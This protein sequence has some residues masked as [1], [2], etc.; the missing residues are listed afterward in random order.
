MPMAARSDTHRLCLACR[1]IFHATNRAYGQPRRLYLTVKPGACR[2]AASL[3][4]AVRQT[5]VLFLLAKS[6]AVF[7]GANAAPGR[8]VVFL[9]FRRRIE[10]RR[11]RRGCNG[12][13]HGIQQTVIFKFAHRALLVG[14]LQ[15]F[16]PFCTHRNSPKLPMPHSGS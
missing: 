9:G 5:R 6:E 2:P 13:S 15:S 4:T 1:R 8:M 14:E 12:Q 10:E 7:W 3:R 11:L 16:R